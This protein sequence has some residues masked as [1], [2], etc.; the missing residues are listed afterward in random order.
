MIDYCQNCDRPCCDC[1]YALE[2]EMKEAR[3]ELRRK[4]L[5]ALY[6][7]GSSSKEVK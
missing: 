4:Q 1:P 6:M 7:L 3:S 2:A 5:T